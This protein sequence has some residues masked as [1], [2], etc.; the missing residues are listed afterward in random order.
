MTATRSV[1]YAVPAFVGALTGERQCGFWPIH[2]TTASWDPT[3]LIPVDLTRS[4]QGVRDGHIVPSDIQVD[5]HL[6]GQPDPGLTTIGPRFPDGEI[7]GAAWLEASYYASLPAAIQPPRVPTA[8]PVAMQCHDYELTSVLYW[9]GPLANRRFYGC[10]AQIVIANQAGLT[11]VTIWPPGKSLAPGVQPVGSYW[12][13]FA[14]SA[15]PSEPGFTQIGPGAADPKQGALFLDR[16]TSVAIALAGPK[17]PP[18]LG[19]ASPL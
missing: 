12:I 7:Q 10:Y 11:Q 8:T 3:K 1:F 6:V 17:V 14:R 5:D 18:F 4:P 13:D 9:D 2:P 15:H 16:P 19:L